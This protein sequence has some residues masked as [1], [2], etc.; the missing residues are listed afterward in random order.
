[1]P[2]FNLLDSLPKLIAIYALYVIKYPCMREFFDKIN[3]RLAEFMQ[4]RYGMD[5]LNKFLF[6]VA[7][8]IMLVQIFIPIPFIS[9]FGWIVIILAIVRS[10]SRNYAAR[11]NENA[12]YLKIIKGPKSWATRMKKSKTTLYFKCPDCK[13]RLSVP[14][15]KGKLRIIC[16]KCKKEIFKNT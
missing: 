15:G 6:I 7:I 4:G 9:I 16:P 14:K 13:T 2:P 11:E 10:L 12:K 3:L 5:D 1:M 8:V